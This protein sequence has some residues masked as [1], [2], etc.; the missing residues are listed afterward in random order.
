MRDEDIDY[1]DI[2]E[3]DAE[4]FETACVVAPPGKKQVTVRQ[5]APKGPRHPADSPS[6]ATDSCLDVEAESVE[7]LGAMRG[8]T[9]ITGDIISPVSE[10]SDWNVYRAEATSGEDVGEV[11]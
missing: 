9:V 8:V 6:E 1:S 5:E 3:L 10:L 11:P 7:W 4:I 2:P